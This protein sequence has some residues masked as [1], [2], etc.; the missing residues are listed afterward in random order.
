MANGYF[1]DQVR[2]PGAGTPPT[3]SGLLS[4]TALGPKSNALQSRITSVLSASYADLEIRDALHTLDARQIHNTA[5][6][7][8]NLRLDAQKEL[9]ECNGEVIR[10]FGQVAEQL[11]RIGT[12]IAGLNDT[13]SALRTHITAATRE[14]APILEESS[15]LLLQRRQAENRQQLLNAFMSHFL[16]SD[17]DLAVLTSTAEPVTDAF[18]TTLGRVKKIHTDSQVLLGSENQRLGLEI[19]DQSSKHLNAA[20]QKLFRWTQRELRT[21]DLENPQLSS[22]L[23]RAL[24][25][26]AERPALFQGCLDFLAESREHVLSDGFYAALTGNASSGKA[27]ELSAHDPLRYVSDMLAWAH[28]TTVG[29]REALHALF[30]GGGEEISQTIRA[31]RKSVP[32]LHYA[33]GKEDE[34][35]E[36]ADFDGT[37]ALNDLVD[38]D[39]SGVVR[40]L[41]QRVEQIVQSHEDA[42]LSY[43]IANLVAFYAG[44]FSSL[45]GP[46]STIVKALQPL[47]NT[48]LQHFRTI[49]RDHIA[50]LHADVAVPATNDLGPPDFLSEALDTLKTL[51]K[52][53][54]TSLAPA[55]ASVTSSPDTDGSQEDGFSPVL[56]EALEPY[57]AGCENVSKRLSPPHSQI[58]AVNC[59]NA[60]RS[61]LRGYAFTADKAAELEDTVEEMKQQLIEVM[62]DWFLK[63]SGLGLLVQTLDSFSDETENVYMQ[64]VKKLEIMDV[65]NLAEIASILDVWL[66]AAMED[67][68]AFVGQLE[69]K[70]VI[71]DVSE[72]AADLFVM[73][74]ERVE[75]VLMKADEL[76]IAEMEGKEE[77]ELVLLR[78]VFPRTNDEIKVLLS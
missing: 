16:L 78:D 50:N 7:R 67:A 8:R 47:R 31:G 6:T 3:A 2:S 54:D 51:C 10:D 55:T 59:L 39:L 73:D 75:D 62:H 76:T 14:T 13:C 11:K 21:L 30:I 26:L 70:T 52:S 57:L 48:A 37:K 41:R 61:A 63:E 64:R 27:I 36:A 45:L 77:E 58:F 72:K 40:Q 32:W 24:R 18:F 12:A 20:F 74:F 19:L 17:S 34:D 15:A 28:S 25:V 9:I 4:P 1:H 5:D 68:R 42:T 65:E 46:D 44:I 22:L 35:D 60:A 53:Y 56:T 33:D 23:R 66:P 43:Q 49:M 29:E 69:D 38:R 71:R